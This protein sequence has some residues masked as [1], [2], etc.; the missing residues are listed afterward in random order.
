M[1]RIFYAPQETVFDLSKQ[2]DLVC[3]GPE[4]GGKPC[5]MASSGI[6]LAEG[7]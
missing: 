7:F 3:D 2:F 1:R 5:A 4:P 6:V